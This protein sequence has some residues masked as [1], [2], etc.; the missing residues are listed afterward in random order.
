MGFECG[1]RLKEQKREN[2]LFYLGNLGG[3]WDRE[4]IHGA[5][6]NGSKIENYEGEEI[7]NE[8]YEYIIPKATWTK[9][10]DKI[11][12]LFNFCCSLSERIVNQLN[13]YPYTGDWPA[14]EDLSKKDSKIFRDLYF[15]VDPNN[16]SEL[17]K[18]LRLY[19]IANALDESELD[20]VIYW[21]SW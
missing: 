9:I 18:I 7:D 14:T 10:A 19:E 8:E 3:Y 15:N 17:H 20:S 5:V 21:R 4:I 13:D 2:D 16:E 12:P 11:R 1:V 6:L